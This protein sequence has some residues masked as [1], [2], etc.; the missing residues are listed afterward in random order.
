MNNQTPAPK[1]AAAFF[2]DNKLEHVAVQCPN[3]F[4]AI[5]ET[6]NVTHSGKC[7]ACGVTKSI[8]D[9]I[10]VRREDVDTSN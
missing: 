3:C 1:N 8:E 6:D 10:V 9:K 7:P 5:S 2:L 4:Y